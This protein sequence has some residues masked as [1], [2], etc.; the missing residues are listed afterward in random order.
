LEAVFSQLR[1][2]T[3]SA[4]EGLAC[5]FISAETLGEVEGLEVFLG[6]LTKAVAEMALGLSF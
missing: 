6:G 1:L 5:V 4:V 2:K 3:L